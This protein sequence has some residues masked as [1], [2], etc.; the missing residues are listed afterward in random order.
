[1]SASGVGL[2]APVGPLLPRRSRSRTAWLAPAISIATMI[3]VWQ[4][5]AAAGLSQRGVLASP[6]DV[7]ASLVENAPLYLNAIIV[8]GGVALRGWLWGAA[9]GLLTALLFV[10]IAATERLLLKVALALF[11]I[12]EVALLPILQVSLPPDTARVTMAA[13]AVYFTMLVTTALGLRSAPGDALTLV[14]AWGGSSLSALRHVRL[15]AA[16]PG[17]LTGLQIGAPAALTGAILGE[18]M[19]TTSGLGAILVGG[20]SSLS[21]ER[22]WSVAVI[23]TAIGSIAYVVLGAVIRRVAPWSVSS[24]A[25]AAPGTAVATRSAGRVVGE[26]GWAVVS[27]AVV[28]LA[29]WGFIL[30]LDLPPFFAKTPLDVATLLAQPAELAVIL[31]AL[32]TTLAHAGIGFVV[33]LIAGVV[34]ATLFLLIPSLEVALAPVAV[35]L[36]AVPIV[37]VIPLLILALGRGIVAVAVI[38]AI[39]SFFPTLSTVT[40][41]LRQTPRSALD[42]MRSYDGSVRQ[43][44]LHVHLPFALPAIFAAARLAAP[45]AI[46]G[47]TLAEW[48]AT[49]DGLGNLIARSRSHSDYD[50][51][52]SAAAVLTMVSIIVYG[53][54]SALERRVLRASL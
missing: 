20:L 29:W 33:G 50:M 13:I 30:I 24:S 8:T 1:V 45:A 31:Q 10:Q 32:G 19:G 12:P 3:V 42:L 27:I 46:L 40:T 36:R 38:T 17:M 34:G 37:V 25:V 21:L 43:T 28:L 23:I 18:F 6:L 14:H 26:L 54:V 51:L 22:V 44:L 5:L 2:T 49:G 35:A 4:L 41:A 53:L 39:I 9:L 15:R 16:V 7:V 11:C 52:W 48:L 47:A